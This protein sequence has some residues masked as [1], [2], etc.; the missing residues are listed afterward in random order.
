[1]A[2]KRNLISEEDQYL[3]SEMAPVAKPQEPKKKNKHVE[4]FKQLIT[5]L[6]K[7]ISKL[8]EENKA[9]TNE[10][11]LL[12]EQVKTLQAKA[13]SYD[14]II[15]SKSLFSTSVIAKSFGWS[16]IKLNKYLEEKKVQYFKS[17]I[18]MLYQKYASR[19][20]TGEQFYSYY[21][22]NKG[23]K[24][25]RAHTYWTMKGYEFITNLLKE[26]KLIE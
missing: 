24:H 2:K 11:K 7:E 12:E 14:K 19:G 4:A 21:E 23:N 26:D 10:K 15:N 5:S 1:M 25:S 16:A 18:W 3:S 20:Y 9:L 6:E 22:D 13:D 8:E 17:G